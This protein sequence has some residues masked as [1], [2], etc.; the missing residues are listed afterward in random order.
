MGINDGKRHRMET[1]QLTRQLSI[2]GAIMMI[3]GLGTTILTLIPSSIPAATSVL[4]TA[5]APYLS[6]V[7]AG[8]L[9]VGIGGLLTTFGPALISM[10]T[11][12]MEPFL[13]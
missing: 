5:L 10:I 12:F 3:V 7:T 4:E 13:V 11:N 6:G 2:L 8:E 9:S 1:T